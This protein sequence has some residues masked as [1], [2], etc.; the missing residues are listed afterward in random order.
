VYSANLLFDRLIEKAANTCWELRLGIRTRRFQEDT[1]WI[2]SEHVEYRPTSYPLIFRILDFLELTPSDVV[3]DLGCGKG[4]VVCCAA[5]YRL[6]EVIGVEDVSILSDRAEANAAVMRGRNSKISIVK[7]KVEDF[8]YARGTVLYLNNPFGPETLKA[9]LKRLEFARESS[10]RL[11]YFNPVHEAV[12][13]EKGWMELYAHWSAS[14]RL[15]IAHPVSFWR[16][17]TD[18]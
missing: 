2:T 7:C 10:R 9:V 17:K 11:V 1:P 4:R 12:L 16:T 18:S 8:D 6:E 14:S 3:V 15:G 13:S 5:R